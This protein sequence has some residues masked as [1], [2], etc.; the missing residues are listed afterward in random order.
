MPTIKSSKIV[1]MVLPPLSPPPFFLHFLSTLLSLFYFRFFHYS[2]STSDTTPHLI[3]F[4]S[5][6]SQSPPHSL[7]F[8]GD[9][10]DTASFSIAFHKIWNF[11]RFF[12]PSFITES[13]NCSVWTS[14]GT[15][16]N[17][18]FCILSSSHYLRQSH[19]F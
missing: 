5:S 6:S 12:I 3:F 15:Q 19:T 18:L 4:S 16:L 1:H 11:F 8:L 13:G 9:G 14:R 10:Y 2:S 7:I 17:R